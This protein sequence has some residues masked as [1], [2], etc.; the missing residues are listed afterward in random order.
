M[1]NE[2]PTPSQ[3]R[4]GTRFISEDGVVFKSP[5]WIKIPAMTIKDGEVI[6]GKVQVPLVAENVDEK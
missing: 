4:P 1:V 5:G 6:P 2:L 3:L